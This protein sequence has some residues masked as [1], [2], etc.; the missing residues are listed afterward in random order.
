MKIAI[1]VESGN[2]NP[3]FGHS[4]EFVVFEAEGGSIKG[5]K[6]VANNG[7]D[8]NHMGLAG[9][10]K[11][12][13]VDVVITGGIGAPMIKALESSGF[14]VI[15]GASGEVEKVA[16]DYINGRLVVRPTEVCGCGGHGHGH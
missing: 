3:H 5:K 6:I 7:L 15:T 8:H 9:L 11:L 16:E 10:L 4:R 12:Q 2:V 14:K 13:G 1:P